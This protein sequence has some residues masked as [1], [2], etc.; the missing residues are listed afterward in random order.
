MMPM[1]YYLIISIV[2]F[3]IM[4]FIKPFLNRFTDAFSK[5]DTEPY[6]FLSITVSMFWIAA[7]PV[8]AIIF[9]FVWIYRLAEKLVKKLDE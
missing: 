6:I 7:I 4:I 1:L 5:H 9:I 3:T 8:V 2:I